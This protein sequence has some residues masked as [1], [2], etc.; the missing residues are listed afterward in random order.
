MIRYCDYKYIYYVGYKPQLFCIRT[1]PMEQND[2]ID[3]PAYKEIAAQLDARLRQICNPEAVND[4][5]KDKQEKILSEHGGR[6]QVLASFEPVLFSPP[7]KI[8]Q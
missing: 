3:D 2:L 6:E 7:P 8:T 1:D 5:I 4:M